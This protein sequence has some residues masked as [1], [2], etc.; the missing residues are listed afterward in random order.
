LPCMFIQALSV[1][2]LATTMLEVSSCEED[3]C[4]PKLGES[5]GM[6]FSGDFLPH[7]WLWEDG[8]LPAASLDP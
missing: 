4:L 2:A 8:K 6:L 5:V 3:P 7:S 1:V